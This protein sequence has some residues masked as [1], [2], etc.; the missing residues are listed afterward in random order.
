MGRKSFGMLRSMLGIATNSG[1]D[2]SDEEDVTAMKVP[3]QL[4]TLIEH[5]DAQGNFVGI[6]ADGPPIVESE[7][8]VIVAVD[9]NITEDRVVTI[10]DSSDGYK[11]PK[12]DWTE[13]E[14][15]GLR[16]MIDRR[17]KEPGALNDPLTKQILKEIEELEKNQ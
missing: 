8:R 7:M 13:E 14:I 6:D 11:V 3:D 2:S 9:G 16:A 10:D 5:R 15:V 12:C 4:P 17:L 1:C